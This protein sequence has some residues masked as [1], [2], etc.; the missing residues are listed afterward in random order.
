M[1]DNSSSLTKDAG[2]LIV[3]T[4]TGGQSL[5]SVDGPGV[6]PRT[7]YFASSMGGNSA[8]AG[9]GVSQFTIS[10]NQLAM[11]YDLVTQT[12]GT[13]Q[14]QDA[15]TVTSS[16]GTSTPSPTTSPSAVASATPSPGM[17]LAQDSFQRANQTYWGT[18]TDG[19]VWGG[20]ANGNSRVSVLNHTGQVS[21]KATYSY[22]ASLGPGVTNAEVLF[23]GSISS[24][25]GTNLGAILRWTD[26]QDWYKA[27][28]DGSNLVIQKRV[29]G[30]LTKLKSVAAKATAGTSY[31]L[32]F[33]AT[34]STLS[35]SVWPMSGSD[36]GSWMV[37]AQDSDHSSGNCGLHTLLQS[38]GTVTLRLDWKSSGLRAVALHRRLFSAFTQLRTQQ[39]RPAA[40]G[41]CHHSQL[42]G[43]SSAISPDTFSYAWMMTYT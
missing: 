10:A 28:I 12:Q 38:G 24:F 20:D 23:S 43:S 42:L 26:S 22:G 39:A 14:F 31:T 9:Y 3:D 15:F 11:K 16:I 29:N 25:S 1:V 34:R 19:Q 33:N 37:A 13:T 40:C 8:N 21:T 7:H 2:T 4:G 36:P 6:D 32:R 18:A 17:T 30:T 41:P 27:F 35:A 5:V